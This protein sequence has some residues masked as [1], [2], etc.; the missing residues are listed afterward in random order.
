MPMMTLNLALLFVFRL[1]P[2]QFLF[3]NRENLLHCATEFVGGFLFGRGWHRVRYA[4][5]RFSATDS[6]SRRLQEKEYRRV[7]NTNEEPSRERSGNA[8]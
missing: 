2:N 4:S 1:A 6:I 5:I 3:R 7:N 8:F